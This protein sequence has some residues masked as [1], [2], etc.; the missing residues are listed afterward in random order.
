MRS[1]ASR[2]PNAPV[3]ARSGGAPQG[4]FRL[5]RAAICR[6]FRRKPFESGTGWPSFYQPLENAVGK[7]EDRTL[8][9]APYRSALSPLRRLV[10]RP[11]LRR[12]GPKPTGLRYC[13]DGFALVFHLAAPS[14]T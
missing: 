14:A 5:R 3:R 1:C 4:R 8:R 13:M 10:I 2:A 7:T 11:R 12:D 6:C 9:H